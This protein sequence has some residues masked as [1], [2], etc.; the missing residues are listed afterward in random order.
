MPNSAMVKEYKFECKLTANL[1]F[2]VMISLAIH[3]T[4][5]AILS[6]KDKLHINNGFKSGHSRIIQVVIKRGQISLKPSVAPSQ[7]LSK[8]TKI[9][10]KTTVIDNAPQV[11]LLP[12]PDMPKQEGSQESIHTQ[13]ADESEVVHGIAAPMGVPFAGFGGS[14]WG[15]RS[16][17][18]R[19]LGIQNSSQMQ[20][21]MFEKRQKMNAA[22]NNLYNIMYQNKT[23]FICELKLSENIQIGSLNCEP[24][25]RVEMVRSIL[26][27]TGIVWDES[28]KDNFKECLVI[29]IGAI[30]SEKLNCQKVP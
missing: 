27:S 18:H 19:L 5:I 20:A 9:I 14:P 7:T 1:F 2:A 29:G 17:P 24:E 4:F 13:N 11:L 30:K 23:E 15:A 12:D 6:K 8:T 21:M 10:T 25:D 16:K 28:I 3:A 26:G 22:M